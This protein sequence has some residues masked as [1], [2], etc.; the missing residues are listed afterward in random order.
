MVKAMASAR[1]ANSLGAIVVLTALAPA[2]CGTTNGPGAVG[3]SSGTAGASSSGPGSG[4][5][6]SSSGGG[7]GDDGGGGPRSSSS[8]GGDDAGGGSSGAGS[9][10]SGGGDDGGGGSSS[11]GGSAASSS[12]GAGS[13]SSGGTAQP[14]T[15]NLVIGNTTTQQWFDGGFLT[16][17]GIDPTH[18]EMFFFGHHYIDS[19]ANPNDPAWSTPLDNKHM[20]AADGAMPDRVIFIATRPPP[21]PAESFYQTNLTSIVN[22]IKAKYPTV[23]QIDLM[24][25]IRAPNN[26]PC[27]GTSAT[28]EQIIPPAEDQGVTATANAFPGLVVPVPPLY[29]LMCSDFNPGAPQY[30]AAGAKDIATVYG[31]YFAK[32]L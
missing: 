6:S 1:F 8:G 3:S 19:W 21:Y 28:S 16:Y 18:W 29:V 2:G 10:S 13:S 9:S 15:C 20:C 5:S 7:A 24:T 14:F 31:A 17:P 4:G 26:V 32:N 22:D 25:D 12:S 27:S 30:T 11:S 23:K